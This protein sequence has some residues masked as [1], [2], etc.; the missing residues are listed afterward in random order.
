MISF[1]Q[2]LIDNYSQ[3]HVAPDYSAPHRSHSKTYNENNTLFSSGIE[4]QKQVSNC[5]SHTF[6]NDNDST[7]DSTIDT[8][9]RF[10]H[11]KQPETLF[12][13]I[14]AFTDIEALAID[15]SAEFWAVVDVNTQINSNG[16]TPDLDLE[17]VVILD[18]LYDDFF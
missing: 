1:A 16:N 5:S 7:Y 9:A 11:I 4:D 14:K 8:S 6:G 10:H 13:G 12:L 18:T 17:L 2:W 15:Q 3:Q